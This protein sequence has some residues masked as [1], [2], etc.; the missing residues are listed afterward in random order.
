MNR[1]SSRGE[2]IA[3]KHKEKLK[4]DKYSQRCQLIDSD[5][6][7]NNMAFE[8]YGACSEK[9]EDFLEKMVKAASDVNHVPYSVLLNYWRKH[10]AVTLQTLNAR[11][12]TQAYL[13]LF[14]NGGG[15]LERDFNST[16]AFEMISA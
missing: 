2:H 13:F 14:D 6:M 3:I 9:F 4:N 7:H 5:F 8:I 15:N 11:L 1:G 16:R 12:I 10:F